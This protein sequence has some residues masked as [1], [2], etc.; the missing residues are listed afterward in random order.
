MTTPPAKEPTPIWHKVRC[1]ECG[2]VLCEVRPGS[3]IKKMCERCK[4]VR[5][6]AV[7]A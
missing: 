3:T 5:V 2:K 7:A 6:V 4:Q 1:P